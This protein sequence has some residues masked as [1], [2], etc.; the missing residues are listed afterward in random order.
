MRRSLLA[1]AFVASSL[2]LASCAMPADDPNFNAEDAANAAFAEDSAADA[3]AATSATSS[4]VDA[5]ANP[6][7]IGVDA[8]LA[9]APA[10]GAVLVTV[11]DGSDQSALLT[12]SMTE[13]AAALGWTV[14]EVTGADT[15]MGAIDAFDEALAM[16]PAGI[17]IMG[18]FADDM[19]DGLAAAETAG[20][21]VIC[22]G[23]SSFAPAGV[24]DA[25]IDGETQNDA[26]GRLL[27]AYVYG[28]KA[29]AEDAGVEMFQIPGGAVTIFNEAFNDELSS[30]CRE[31]ST[32]E[33]LIDP[34]FVDDIPYFVTDTMSISLGR[35]AL[36]DSGAISSGVNDSLATG[37]LFEPVIVIGRGANAEDIA[38]M[39]ATTFIPVAGTETDP[40]ADTAAADMAAGDEAAAEEDLDV[41]GESLN[42]DGFSTPEEAASLQAWIALPVPV[43]GWRVVDQFARILGGEAPVDAP[44]PS[45]LITPENAGSVVLDPEGNYIGVDGFQQEFLTLWG[46][47]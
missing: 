27:A 30:L 44:L 23:C 17:H 32:T 13:A 7:T 28:N 5:M 15:A 4:V 9:A 24:T 38:S 14:E 21:P 25:S 34:D 22:T 2:V 26:W 16:E 1:A 45:Q 37:D 41:T 36:L 35:W 8:P 31:C 12:A 19:V 18:T 46:V 43:M 6:T 29:P 11:S 42:L 10:A 33:N 39:Q 47:Q 3:E 20:V 40:A